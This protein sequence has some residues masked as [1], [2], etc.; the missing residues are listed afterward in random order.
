M[1]GVDDGVTLGEGLVAAAGLMTR[2]VVT[3]AVVPAVAVIVT[4]KLP[5]AFG[6][7]LIVPVCGLIVSPAG[8]P[9]AAQVAL[10]VPPVAV[11]PTL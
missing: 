2:V 9:L 5:D 8:R 4:G 3:D 6:V 7:P 11:T 1:T 10:P